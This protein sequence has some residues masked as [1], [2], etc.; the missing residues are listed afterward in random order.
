[1]GRGVRR[2]AIAVA[3][4]RVACVAFVACVACATAST[5]L[6]AQSSSMPEHKT[7]FTG[8]DAA[9]AGGFL[10]ASAGISIFDARLEHFFQDSMHLHVRIGRELD[11]AFTH[12]NETTL[13]V[14]GLAVYAIARVSGQRVIASTAIHVSESV[15][16][17]SIT[18]QL[19][20][21]PLGRTRP[22][23]ADKPFENQ[24]D[25]HF[26]HGFGHFQ[27]RAFPSIHSSSGFAAASAIVAEVHQHSPGATV[28][29]AI[30]AY[31]L[32]LTPG[33]S[34]MYL[35]QHWASDIFAGAAM[36]TYFGW[37]VVNYSYSHKTTAVDRVFL[38]KGDRIPIGWSITF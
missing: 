14:G 22:R 1:M 28:L 35:G 3:A 38:G 9:A 11:Q 20:R 32:A 8:H 25:F 19:I 26:M 18:S 6:A 23:D 27:Q 5:R 30:P 4:A 13:T 34:R 15:F 7:F 36:G 31:A 2:F 33:L 12:I 29:V 37:R 21:G 24:Y 10:A 16:A 17:A